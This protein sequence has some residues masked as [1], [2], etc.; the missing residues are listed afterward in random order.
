MNSSDDTRTIIIFDGVCNFCNGA[1][2][3]I[4]KKDVK[5]IFYFIPNQSSYGKEL[6]KEYSISNSELDSVILIKNG[7]CYTKSDAALE[8][9]KELNGIY[10][11][12]YVF[13][14]LPKRLRDYFY[15]IF[16]KNRYRVFGKMDSCMIPSKKLRKRF[17]L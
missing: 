13:K 14:I 2:N 3:F 6:F 17:I 16:A 5:E 10:S 11:S 15:D 8:I 1:V 9:I 7:H 12:L 4:I